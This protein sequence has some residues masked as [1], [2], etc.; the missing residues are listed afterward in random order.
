MTFNVYATYRANP[1]TSRTMW[2]VL[3]YRE[4]EIHRWE[5]PLTYWANADPDF[6][7]W[8]PSEGRQGAW[9]DEF[10]AD[11]LAEVLP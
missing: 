7:D 4:R 5:M 11:R 6:G 2:A 9:V 3:R 1:D 10:V 8:E